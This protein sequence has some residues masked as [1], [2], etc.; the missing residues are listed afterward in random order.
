MRVF[1]VV[2]LSLMILYT[3]CSSTHHLIN[4]YDSKNEFEG[5]KAL[6]KLVSG[7]EVKG[8]II[9]IKVD[10]LSEIES[11]LPIN[12]FLNK[13]IN[14]L[15]S[16]IKEIQLRDQWQG[17]VDGGG[18]GFLGGFIIGAAIV[19]PNLGEPFIRGKVTAEFI[20]IVGGI[21]GIGCGIIGIP[22]G[23]II[24]HTDK[25]VIS[26]SLANEYV[27]IELT[28]LPEKGIDEYRLN[29]KNQGNMLK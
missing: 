9:E 8:E 28:E 24:G 21:I 3:G 14:I 7:E 10:T 22:I 26:S 12:L 2:L 29:L 19:I 4:C 15:T 13:P 11:E 20:P 1:I 23:A 27:K 18:Y 6:I 17:A 16:E 5:E 25:Y